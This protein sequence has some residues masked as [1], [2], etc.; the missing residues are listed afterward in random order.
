MINASQDFITAVNGNPRNFKAKIFLDSNEVTCNTISILG[1]KG[2]QDGEQFTVGSVFSSS[3]EITCADLSGTLENEDIEVQIGV[4]KDNGTYEYIT[5]GNYTVIRAQKSGRLSV[6][7]CV[8]FISSKFNVMLPDMTGTPTVAGVANAIQTATGVPI[9]FPDTPSGT[10]NSLAKGLTGL[11]CR[12]ALS[13]IAFAV[14]GF[15]T[16]NSTGGVEIHEFSIPSSTYELSTRRCLTPPVVSHD[17]FEMT[18]IKVIVD[19]EVYVLTTDTTVTSGKIYY[20]RT[21]TGTSADP[22]VY[23]EVETPTGNP[24]TQGWYELSEISYESGY[25]IRQTYENEYVSQSVF[26]KL[27]SVLVGLEYNTAEVDM[28]LGDPRIE[29]WDCLE[30]TEADETTHIVP[31]H[32]IESTFDGGFASR[33]WSIG[34]GVSDKEVTGSVT[35]QV[36]QAISDLSVTQAAADQAKAAATS[37]Q[38]S[39][40]AAQ[41]ILDDMEDAAEAAGTT[42]TQMQQ[43][44]KRRRAKQWVLL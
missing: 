4:L 41:E 29:P 34:E 12:A 3:V 31:C 44:L 13:V 15:A 26:N 27:A 10:G 35:E 42:L 22:Y 9:S 28:S 33:I 32:L 14:G 18:G 1:R 16:E 21:G 11:S 36:R 19:P 24:R 40:D 2:A 25:P 30:V 5:Y 39:A 38:R 43:T 23:A 20:T 8:G 7:T 17:P 6:I 37:A